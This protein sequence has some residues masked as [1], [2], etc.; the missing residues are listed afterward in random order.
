[1]ETCS[2]PS[3]AITSSSA[4]AGTRASPTTNSCDESVPDARTTRAGRRRM[5]CSSVA[6]ARHP[7]RGLRWCVHRC[8]GYGGRRP[9]RREG[10][11]AY[12]PMFAQ[13]P[14]GQTLA[15]VLKELG[16]ASRH[17]KPQAGNRH[18][19]GRREQT[20]LTEAS[21]SVLLI[22]TVEELASLLV[23][24][25]ITFTRF[26]RQ[27]AQNTVA[28]LG[29]RVARHMQQR[30]GQKDDDR[31]TMQRHGLPSRASQ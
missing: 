3:W 30:G 26:E 19:T 8:C 18:G 16:S 21:N 28:G 11:R 14:L 9:R 6:S 20:D 31:D 5:L 24:N 4:P 15:D 10:G 23:P 22:G 17:T 2:R 29:S 12:Y 7:R 13:C 1:M 27:I 25:S